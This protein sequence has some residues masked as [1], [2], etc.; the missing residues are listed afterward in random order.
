MNLEANSISTIRHLL[1]EGESQL[2]PSSGI[3]ELG[4]WFNDED[5]MLSVATPSLLNLA[6]DL[7]NEREAVAALFAC[8]CRLRESW[9]NLVCARLRECG[10]RRDVVEVSEAIEQLG[11][12]SGTVRKLLSTAVLAATGN[13]DLETKLLGAPA[14]QAVVWPA[15]LRI[16]GATSHLLEGKDARPSK[17]LL[18]VEPLDARRNWCP[19]RILQM[20]QLNGGFEEL[21]FV[22]MGYC[23][24][25]LAGEAAVDE[26]LS[27]AVVRWV[28]LR[29]WATLLAQIVFVQE[30]WIAEQ[31]SGRL[32]LE[33]A[34][35]QVAN[36]Y[37]PQRID[38]VV[39]TAEGEELLCGTLAELVTR[40]LN[41]LGVTL[42][43][44]P[45]E[46]SRLDELLAPVIHVLLEKHVWRFDPRG[47]GSGR[48]GYTIDDEFSTS[49]YRAFGSK[50][51]Y[52]GCSNL[53]EA[54]RITCEQWA[55][56]KVR[57][58]RLGESSADLSDTSL[59]ESIQ[60]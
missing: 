35:D 21:Q 1:R 14:D 48:P 29:P 22:L 49:C 17:P 46:A 11:P 43:A 3:A 41:R 26:P 13:Q 23:G 39:T 47:G 4:L 38:A 34:D 60:Q 55:Q 44:R 51:F 6:A 37:Q 30:A 52:R 16:L 10:N 9:L 53:T 18:C 36:A 50:H 57:A 32:T 33:L 54:I 28:L 59:A 19:G 56:E 15:L 58:A 2:L 42:L 5:R 25:L 45:E 40:V 7:P 24:P 20:P 12:A 27:Q 31:I 8:D